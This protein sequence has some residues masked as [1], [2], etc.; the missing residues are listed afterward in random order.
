MAT[1]ML[2]ES[3]KGLSENVKDMQK[4]QSEIKHTLTEIQ[5]NLQGLNKR[6]K[7]GDRNKVAAW[8]A[9]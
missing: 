9:S 8:A 6:V 5:N 1:R 2:N 7:E 4:D 3:C